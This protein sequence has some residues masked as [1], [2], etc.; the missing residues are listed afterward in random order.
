[1]MRRSGAVVEDDRRTQL[2]QTVAGDRGLTQQAVVA[3]LRR[4]GE[5]ARA[6][7]IGEYNDYRHEA[8]KRGA[9]D[10]YRASDAISIDP[11]IL[12]PVLVGW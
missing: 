8:G 2:D 1:M 9:R 12:L 6:G 11:C 3:R 10:S 7:R 5:G 4:V